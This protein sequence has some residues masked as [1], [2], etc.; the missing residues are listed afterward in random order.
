[1]HA[2]AKT[3]AILRIPSYAIKYARQKAIGIDTGVTPCRYVAGDL[4]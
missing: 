2:I 3:L 4:A 1:M